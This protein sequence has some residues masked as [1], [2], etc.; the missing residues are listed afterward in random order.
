MTE[1]RASLDPAV[2][3]SFSNGGDLTVHGFRIDLPSPD[4]SEAV[5]AALFIASLGLLELEDGSGILTGLGLDKT[6]TE[7]N[8][9]DALELLSRPVD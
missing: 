9:T 7:T 5:I 3:F 6:T 2:S 1:H 4:A 8:I